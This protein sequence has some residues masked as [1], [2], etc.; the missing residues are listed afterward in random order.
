MN[1]KE[2]RATLKRSN[3]LP[4]N[5]FERP[6]NNVDQ[7]AAGWQHYCQGQ[8]A[9]AETVCRNILM[10]D[11]AQVDAINLLGLVSQASGQHYRAIKFFAKAI[12][13]NGG[14]VAHHYNIALLFQA[15]EHWDKAS[16][17]FTRAIALGLDENSAL[18]IVIQAPAI[19]GCLQRLEVAWPRRLTHVELFGGTSIAGVSSQILLHSLLQSTWLSNWAIENFLTHVRYLLFQLT[20]ERAPDFQI[21]DVTELR[22]FCAIAQQCFINEYIFSQGDDETRQAIALRDVLE[23]RLAAGGD[24]SPALLVAVAAY[25]PLHSLALAESLL[26]R[27]WGEPVSSLVQQ[28][29]RE[30]LEEKLD[31]G[32]IPA[33]TTI[34]DSFSLQVRQ[35][36]E[37]NPFPRWIVNPP[38]KVPTPELTSSAAVS[39]AAEVREILIAGCGTGKHSIDAAIRFPKARILAVDLSLA[40]LAYARRKTRAAH[41]QNIDYAQADILK[42]GELN[43]SFDRIEVGGVLHHL[44]DPIAGW[45]ILLSLL[46]PHGIMYVGLYSE[47]AR[48]AIVA[49]RA[50][51]AQRSYSSTIEGIR[52]CRDAIYRGGDVSLQKGLTTLRDFYSASGCRDLLFNVVEHRFTLPQIKAFLAEHNLSFL[53]FDCTPEI[54]EAF[55]RQFPDPAARIDLDAWHKFETDNPDTFI[56]MY[57]FLIRKN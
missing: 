38:A 28:Q 36:Y 22:F 44:A 52:T 8:F 3:E 43:R 14:S 6:Q 17:H 25:F 33:L 1:R 21:V 34:E 18:Q 2:R 4:H 53:G 10:R 51:I 48:R 23:E 19:A 27:D 5:G 7:L 54:V 9:Q 47:I 35:Q 32:S 50:L 11:A 41:L 42:L 29:I 26:Q 12:K 30:P 56:S 31:R 57:Q 55:G 16:A 24:I 20:A 49:C 39:N 46:R 40:S 45:R 13:T 37:E 15:L